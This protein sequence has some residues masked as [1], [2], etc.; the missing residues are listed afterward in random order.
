MP[1]F[2]NDSVPYR[3]DSEGDTRMTVTPTIDPIDVKVVWDMLISAVNAAS[4]AEQLSA[5]STA[6]TEA[7]DFGCTLLDS[8]GRLVATSDF[9]LPSF[10][11]MTPVAVQHLLTQGAFSTAREGD[12]FICND[13]W[14]AAAQISDLLVI[15]PLIAD[16]KIVGFATSVAHNPD[17]GGVRGWFSAGDV[18]E[19]GLL[20]PPLK[21]LEEGRKNT[22]LWSILAANSRI[23][24]QT[25]GDVEAQ[26]VAVETIA[27]RTESILAEQEWRDLDIWSEEV[28]G[29]SERL[30][31]EAVAAGTYAPLFAQLA[32]PARVTVLRRLP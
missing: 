11:L 9:G 23:P 29:R 16:A 32:A 6:V 8:H 4:R 27:S 26:I 5:F 24:E 19:E 1:R 18:F 22:T 30:M 7:N 25:L 10:C 21:L 15:R 3:V 20:I 2:D 17:I 13:P 12:V 31:K 14:L 28:V